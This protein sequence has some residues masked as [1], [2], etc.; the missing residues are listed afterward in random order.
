MFQ[1]FCNR[2]LQIQEQEKKLEKGNY[3]QA[4]KDF[5]VVMPSNLEL[6]GCTGDMFPGPWEMPELVP[7]RGRPSVHRKKTAGELFRKKQQARTGNDTADK[8]RHCCCCR[9][10]GH[11]EAKCPLKSRFSAK[12][13]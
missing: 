13:P 1:L 11:T 8:R 2:S 6:H 12:K 3:I 4:F 9:E 5:E 7:Q 10:V